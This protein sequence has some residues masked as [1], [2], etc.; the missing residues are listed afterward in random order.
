MSR[1]VEVELHDLEKLGQL[2]ERSTDLGVNQ[3]GDPRLD[4][5]KRQD[6]VR[7]ALAKA[8]VDAR[9]NAE[10]M[11]KAA[12]AKLGNARTI[13][14]NTEF[15]PP[16]M[17]MVRAMAMERARPKTAAPYQSGEMTFNAT[18]RSVRS[19]SAISRSEPTMNTGRIAR[20]MH[21]G[22]LVAGSRRGACDRS[23]EAAGAARS[24]H[25]RRRRRS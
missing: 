2:L 13:N 25:S 9:Q 1:Q 3:M 4:S 18:V 11:A 15:S 24:S 17:P 10:V 16:P 22:R 21:T 20:G 12:G 5:S 23:S 19:D 8:V 7:E 6:L 14:A